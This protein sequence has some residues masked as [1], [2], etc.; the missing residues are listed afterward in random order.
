[1]FS[2]KRGKTV[3]NIDIKLISRNPFQPRRHFDRRE[4]EG[5]ADSIKRN[6]V[7]Q[8]LT[9]RK[10]GGGY[11]LIAGERRLRASKIAG[12]ES[13]PCIVTTVDDRR[14][15]LLSLIE[16]LQ[17]CDLNFFEEA[18]GLRNLIDTW[19]VTQEEAAMRLGKSQSAIANKMRL[20]RL[21]PD[22]QI[23]ILQTG[24]TE[25]HARELLRLTEEDIR[26][27]A[28]EH[29][30]ERSLNVEQTSQYIDRLLEKRENE[31]ENCEPIIK[32]PYLVRDLRLFMNTLSRAVET[33][34]KSGVNAES[35][36]L[37]T[38]EYIEYK[39]HIAK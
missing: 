5:M 16:N 31:E 13:V 36:T 27:N 12:L 39:V 37:E 23:R 6:G 17:R 26:A 21:S 14:S 11:E 9:V 32:K 38:D 19:G 22:E 8:P 1:M 20:L 18:A 24:L 28:L 10:V 33:M 15:S 4:L 2:V 3:Y 25:R 30:I 35:S 34:K 29:I 7:I